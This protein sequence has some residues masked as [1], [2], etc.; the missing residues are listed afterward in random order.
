MG[1][2]RAGQSGAKRWLPHAPP[3]LLYLI[4]ALGATFPLWLAPA[5]RIEALSD[6]LLNSYILGWDH[7]A[8]FHQIF[9]FFQANI[10]WPHADALAYGEHLLAP[11]IL[12]LP[13]SLFTDSAVALHNFS[14][15]Q[16]YFLSAAGAYALA[17]YFFGSVP[18]ATVAGLVYG[19]AACRIA[20]SEHIQLAHG[21][22]LPLIVLGFEKVLETSGRRG[23]FLLGI[24][25]L[26]QWLTSW[27]WAVFSF[28]FLV[29]YFAGRCWQS[30]RGLSPRAVAGVVFPLLVAAACVLPAAWP[31]M[32]LKRN[33]ALVRPPEASA[34]LSARPLDYLSPPRRSLLYGWIAAKG[35]DYSPERALFP[36]II[37]VLGFAIAGGAALRR[38]RRKRP[39]RRWSAEPDVQNRVFPVRLCWVITLLMLLFSFGPEM[40]LSSSGER[41]IPLPYALVHRFF[42]FAG[43]MRVPSRWI[44]PASLGLALLAAFSWNEI[45]GR[46]RRAPIAAGLAGSLL[47]AECLTSPLG[48]VEVETEPAPA[49]LWLAQQDYPSPVLEFPILPSDDNRPMLHALWHGQPTVNGT[50]GYFPLGHR[51]FLAEVARFPAP[52]ALAKLR[53]SRV[54]YVVIDK[55][56]S[57]TVAA[58]WTDGRLASFSGVRDFDRH[59]IIDL[60]APGSN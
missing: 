26:G 46:R 11:A 27:Y 41:T 10:F 34:G 18:A 56:L 31:T 45:F 21:E 3:L 25:A 42:P 48:F 35:A 30:R 39:A 24:A 8:L 33:N 1:N 2:R 9:D 6:P 16:A 51:V 4:L 20:Q 13:L 38:E 29:P 53:E 43:V 37:P 12:V 22:F 15:L 49:F 59:V 5:S 19:F 17:H 52:E 40:A 32:Q 47:L 36:G 14:L 55:E 54:R 7:F 57:G 58:D 28:W 23:K 60:A 44:L 50:N